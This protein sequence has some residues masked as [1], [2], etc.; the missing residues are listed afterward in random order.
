M[1]ETSC[2]CG[3]VTIAIQAPPKFV[4]DCN[5]SLCRNSGAAW[6]Y[7]SAGEVRVI[8]NTSIFV[9]PDRELPAVAIHSCSTCHATTHWAL[10]EDYLAKE[11]DADRMGVNMRLFSSELL[12]GVEIRFPDGA[13]W[14]GQSDFGFRRPSFVASEDTAF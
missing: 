9:R 3:A 7:F 2:F 1:T 6:G 13:G 10:T 14:D 4:H 11:P 12:Q 5:C 8:G